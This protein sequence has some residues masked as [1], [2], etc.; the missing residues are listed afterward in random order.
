M[1][2]GT[3]PQYP[4]TR[5]VIGAIDSWPLLSDVQ[6]QLANWISDYYFCPLFQAL[7]LMLPPSFER[8]SICFLKISQ[9]A[10]WCDNISLSGEEANVLGIVRYSGL[11][12]LLQ[13][14]KILGNRRAVRLVSRLFSIGLLERE[15]EIEKPRVSP[16]YER[17]VNLSANRDEIINTLE[18]IKTRA[19]RQAAVLNYLLASPGPVAAREIITR[20][21]GSY[22]AITALAR[23]NII[24]VYQQEISRRPLMPSIRTDVPAYEINQAQQAAISAICHN[25][26]LK[27]FNP[28]LL[29]GITGSGKTEVY[30]QILEKT[31]RS[32]KRAIVLVPEIS[33][34]PQTIKHFTGRFPG[35]V[36][37]MHSRLSHGERFDQWR[38]IKKGEYQV[39]I[40]PRSALFAPQPDLG[41]IVID[42]EHE[43]SYKQD[44]SP[45]YHARDV[46]LEMARLNQATLVLGS[47][48]PDIGSYHQASRGIYQLLCMPDRVTPA[49]R[50]LPAI[51]IV[52]LREELKAG[53]LSIFRRNL[54]SSIQ[55]CLANHQQVIL[56]LNRR[57]GASFVQCRNCGHV[58]TCG[59]CQLSLTYHPVEERLVC[60]QCNFRRIT[61][62]FCAHNVQAEE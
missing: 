62:A 51:E 3:S 14:Q 1:Q 47:A 20:S 27:T 38:E 40:G 35:Q 61:P 46:A 41:L 28:F 43:W 53:N 39:V 8:R 6:L 42:E 16:K 56:F 21:H 12:E 25:L 32:G 13:L 19:P 30:L 50:R 36:A 60:H 31:I 34:T 29:F 49:S 11:I 17:Y 18:L 2:T 22:P 5:D 23:Q 26:E 33:L 48:T 58:I 45:R 44:T 24:R 10:D 7:S 55:Q 59:R 52:D 4:Q 57:G 54:Q 15:W 37:V 9:N